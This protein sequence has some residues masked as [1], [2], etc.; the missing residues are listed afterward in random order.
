METMNRYGI[1]ELRPGQTVLVR[2]GPGVKGLM[3][4][5]IHPAG[6]SLLFAGDSPQQQQ[7]GGSIITPIN[8]TAGL[9]RLIF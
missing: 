4:S 5:E 2:F 6:G 1:T 9:L 3:A 7:P 8:Q